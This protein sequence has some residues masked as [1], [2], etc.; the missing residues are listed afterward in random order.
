MDNEGMNNKVMNNEGFGEGK[1][2]YDEMKVVGGNVFGKCVCCNA[3]FDGFG[4]G[5]K[6]T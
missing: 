3:C 6:K 4:E 1:N 2:G 5:T